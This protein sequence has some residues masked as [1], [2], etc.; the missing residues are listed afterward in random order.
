MNPFG[1]NLRQCGWPNR[2]VPLRRS[3]WPVRC[4][5]FDNKK[6]IHRGAPEDF[7]D[8]DRQEPTAEGGNIFAV[9]KAGEEGLTWLGSFGASEQSRAKGVYTNGGIF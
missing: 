5:N 4:A 2:C 9:E 8:A 6:L 1:S 7:T 3:L